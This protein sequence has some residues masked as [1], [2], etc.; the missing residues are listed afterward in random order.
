[1]SVA[2]IF[3][4]YASILFQHQ[5][6]LLPTMLK[7]SAVLEAKFEIAVKTLLKAPNLTVQEAMLVANFL[8]KDIENKSMQKIIARHIPG[9]KRAMAALLPP[10]LL[11]PSIIDVPQCHSTQISKLTT[12]SGATEIAGHIQPPKCKQQMMT[13]T[14]SQQKQVEDLKQKRHKVDVHKEA[15]RLYT[16]EMEKPEEAYEFVAVDCWAGGLWQLQSRN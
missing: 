13:A 7:K 2:Y 3:I 11:P 12:L 16:H 4:N 1:V 14:A 15:V 9:G 5:Y 8:T 10:A 6:T